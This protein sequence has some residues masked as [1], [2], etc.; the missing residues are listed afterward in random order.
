MIRI[1]TEPR[2][3]VK[4]NERIIINLFS[5][6]SLALLNKSENFNFLNRIGTDIESLLTHT[7]WLVLACY[8]KAIVT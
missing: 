5:L 2:D 6:T 8:I 3:F 1:L 4:F 7:K